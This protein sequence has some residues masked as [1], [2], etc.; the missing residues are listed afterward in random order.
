MCIDMEREIDREIKR[1]CPYRRARTHTSTSAKSNAKH[2]LSHKKSHSLSL[3]GSQPRHA[4][5]P[6]GERTPHLN[7]SRIR[8]ACVFPDE[9]IFQRRSRNRTLRRGALN[10]VEAALMHIFNWYVSARASHIFH[11]SRNR[12]RTRASAVLVPVFWRESA[13]EKCSSMTARL[14]AWAR[15]RSMHTCTFASVQ[16]YIAYTGIIRLVRGLHIRLYAQ[17]Q[18]QAQTRTRTLF[19]NHACIH[20]S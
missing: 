4:C 19:R 5:I 11:L 3:T 18:M 20:H 2:E 14:R 16:I 12:A 1:K 15:A 9:G 17:T 13:H 8:Y 10:L 6:R 7:P